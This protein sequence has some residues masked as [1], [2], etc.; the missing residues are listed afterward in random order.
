MAYPLRCCTKPARE[1][2][3]DQQLA[4]QL[5]VCEVHE[6][7][8]L[9][10]LL[11][12]PQKAAGFAWKKAQD[13]SKRRELFINRAGFSLLAYLSYKDKQSPDGKVYKV[14]E[15]RRA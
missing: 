13:W 2:V 15:G 1:I 11:G 14:F 6:A 5:W 9:A 8:I 4:N 10:S 3:Q 12:E 7:K